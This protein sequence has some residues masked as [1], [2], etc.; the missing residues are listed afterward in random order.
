V[1]SPTA[2][3]AF[4]VNLLHTPFPKQVPKLDGMAK[5]VHSH[6]LDTNFPMGESAEEDLRTTC[7]MGRDRVAYILTRAVG[8]DTGSLAAESSNSMVAAWTNGKDHAIGEGAGA[9]HG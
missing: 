6:L 3:K 4:D 9:G 7:S 8:A 5:P 1:G 2:G